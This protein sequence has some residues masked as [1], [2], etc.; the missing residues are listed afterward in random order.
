MSA[1]IV[2]VSS[3]PGSGLPWW[4]WWLWR[5]AENGW[6]G[7]ADRVCPGGSRTYRVAAGSG[8]PL[9]DFSATE[10]GYGQPAYLGQP[11]QSSQA[12]AY[13]PP[14]IDRSTEAVSASYNEQSTG[15]W[16]RAP[17]NASGESS[18]KPTTNSRVGGVTAEARGTRRPPTKCVDVSQCAVGACRLPPAQSSQEALATQTATL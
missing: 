6:F 18:F 15:Y 10:T 14:R 11:R 1:I 2:I 5:E 8:I 17:S 12:Y 4:L 13:S 3:A 9:P 16:V 7:Q